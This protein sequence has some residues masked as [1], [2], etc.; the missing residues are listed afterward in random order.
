M[1]CFDEL[2]RSGVLYRREET[3]HVYNATLILRRAIQALQLSLPICRRSDEE[4][5]DAHVPSEL[6]NFLSWIMTGKIQD[7]APC[8]NKRVELDNCFSSCFFLMYCS[9]SF[10]FFALLNSAIHVD[11]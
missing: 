5:I 3:Q 2:S 1:V 11:I 8:L 10:P 6:H 9:I 4:K 7:M